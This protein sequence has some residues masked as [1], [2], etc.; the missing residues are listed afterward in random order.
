MWQEDKTP[1][2]W[3]AKSVKTDKVSTP[4]RQ[5]KW[6]V[7]QFKLKSGWVA[8]SQNPVNKHPSAGEH[9]CDA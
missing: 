4:A 7:M 9:H 2:K 5:A 6:A 1:A 3:N 8:V